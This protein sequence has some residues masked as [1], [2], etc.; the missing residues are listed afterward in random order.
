VPT[1]APK[2]HFTVATPS[3]LAIRADGHIRPG[4]VHALGDAK[5]ILQAAGNMHLL[6]GRVSGRGSEMCLTTGAR[7]GGVE[8][9]P[10]PTPAGVD[11]YA[12]LK[13]AVAQGGAQPAV[14][15]AVT[16][17]GPPLSPTTFPLDRRA[18]AAVVDLGYWV[19]I[20]IP[21]QSKVCVSSLGV[22]WLET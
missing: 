15:T 4:R 8:Y 17:T 5:H 16:G 7:P 22:G 1:L 13:F 9:E 21:A 10:R 11:L 12:A 2:V 18:G 19:R 20:R 14:V 3:P 6:G